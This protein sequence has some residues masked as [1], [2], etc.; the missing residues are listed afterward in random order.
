MRGMRIAGVAMALEM[1]ALS[2][3]V[4]QASDETPALSESPMTT[5]VAKAGVELV[6][7]LELL[8]PHPMTAATE[9]ATAADARSKRGCQG[10]G[11]SSQGGLR[12]GGDLRPGS[13]YIIRQSPHERGP[14]R[15]TQ[16]AAVAISRP[17]P[18]STSPAICAHK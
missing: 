11:F 1:C 12:A 8:D 17:C 16:G 7:L 13:Q 18:D 10:M 5:V 2:N 6:F 9:T 14:V 15:G 3:A 4:C